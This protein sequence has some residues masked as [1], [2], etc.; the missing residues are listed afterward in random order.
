[1]HMAEKSVWNSKFYCL[2]YNL[3]ALQIDGWFAR[4]PKWTLGAK[5]AFIAGKYMDVSAAVLES[6]F[7]GLFIGLDFGF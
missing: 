7:D 2:S 3:M 5:V 1:M 4:T 6:I